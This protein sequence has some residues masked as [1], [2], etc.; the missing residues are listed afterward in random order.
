MDR[1]DDRELAAILGATLNLN[2]TMA[3][4]SQRDKAIRDLKV[5]DVNA[6]VRKWLKPEHLAVIVAGDFKE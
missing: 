4:Y 5:T 6:S 2:R 1:T 3:F